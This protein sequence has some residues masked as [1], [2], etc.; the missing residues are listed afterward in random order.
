MSSRPVAKLS[1]STRLQF[2]I[3]FEAINKKDF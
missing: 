3:Q 1:I 2:L